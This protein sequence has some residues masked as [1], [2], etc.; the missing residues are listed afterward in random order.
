M[1]NLF[2][3]TSGMCKKKFSFRT[4]EK[5]QFSGGGWSHEFFLVHTNAVVVI[6]ITCTFGGEAFTCLRQFLTYRAA[7]ITLT[8]I[9]GLSQKLS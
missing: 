6:I 8:M 9:L 3:N 4:K 1:L 7:T 5:K 2:L